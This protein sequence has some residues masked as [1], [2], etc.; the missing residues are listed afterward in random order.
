M[1]TFVSQNQKQYMQFH[2]QKIKAQVGVL[3]AQ[4]LRTE[5]IAQTL[6]LTTNQVSHIRSYYYS[7]KR[8]DKQVNRRAKNEKV[9][10]IVK[11]HV[12]R[13]GEIVV[14]FEPGSTK[15]AIIGRDGSVTIK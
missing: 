5:V 1:L 6:G 2:N 4:G 8:A 9:A 10:P 15:R 14:E 3:A 13:L 11:N 7:K 12:L